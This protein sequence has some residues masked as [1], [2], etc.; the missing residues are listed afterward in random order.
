MC[1]IAY[2][3]IVLKIQSSESSKSRVVTQQHMDGYICFY[4]DWKLG[5]LHDHKFLTSHSKHVVSLRFLFFPLPF[6]SVFGHQQYFSPDFNKWCNFIMYRNSCQSCKSVKVYWCF[7]NMIVLP[8]FLL[9]L[10]A[11]L[12]SGCN[13]P[14]WWRRRAWIWNRHACKLIPSIQGEQM[15]LLRH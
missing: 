2:D 7:N 12:S 9:E 13:C 6:F 3:S 5:S 11:K 14:C 15:V 4:G 10:V 8:F 1:T